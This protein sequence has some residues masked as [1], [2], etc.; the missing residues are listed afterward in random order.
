MAF[1]FLQQ[2]HTDSWAKLSIT[3]CEVIYSFGILF[4]A[5]E[6]GQR[7]KFAFNEC[8]DMI[9]QFKWY[10][11]PAKIQRRL[12]LILNFAQQ[13]IETKC[14]GSMACNRET[15][16]N[17][18]GLGYTKERIS[19]ILAKLFWLSILSLSNQFSG[20]QNFIFIFHNSSQI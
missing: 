6:L 2:H 15:F 3:I 7:V 14:C 12:P 4:T 11:F 17:V 9:A 5:C 1:F 16:K 18:R 19:E 20:D 10:Y 13:P 8:E